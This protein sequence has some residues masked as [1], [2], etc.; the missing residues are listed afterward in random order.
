[1]FLKRDGNL[2]YSTKDDGS[3]D[4]MINI[5]TQPRDKGREENMAQKIQEI[6]NTLAEQI[7]P[8]NPGDTQVS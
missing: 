4:L 5:T 1:M 8:G 3:N 2:I 6:L 7:E